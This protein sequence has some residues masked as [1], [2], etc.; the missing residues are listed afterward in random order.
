LDKK[1]TPEERAAAIL[2]SLTKEDIIELFSEAGFELSEGTGLI[3]N[4]NNEVIF[5]PTK[6]DE[7]LI[8][9]TFTVKTD[10]K[11]KV[12]KSR[13]NIDNLGSFSFAS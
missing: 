1:L 3:L 10:Y 9:R 7:I 2:E 11:P 8:K 13:F 4:A 6:S 5:E 12:K